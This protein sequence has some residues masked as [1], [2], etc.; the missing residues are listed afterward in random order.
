MTGASI[1]D[2]ALDYIGK[3]WSPVP[4]PFKKKRPVIK[5]WEALRI[6]AATAPR[7]FN[8]AAMNIGVILG[9]ASHDGWKKF[10][11]S[12]ADQ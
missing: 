4:V 1:L 11:N 12:R 10:T 2:I 6:T 5:G 7:Y 8:G 9:E 3:G